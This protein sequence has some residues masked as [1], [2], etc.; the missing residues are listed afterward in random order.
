MSVVHP[1]G[2]RFCFVAHVWDLNNE[3]KN[4]LSVKPTIVG[5]GIEYLTSSLFS[6]S[7]EEIA[8]FF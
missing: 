2:F 4:K 7:Q 8:G 6:G 5:Y 3:E 1:G